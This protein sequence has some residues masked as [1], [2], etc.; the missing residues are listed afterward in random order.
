MR[1]AFSDTPRRASTAMRLWTPCHL[2]QWSR[3][4]GTDVRAHALVAGEDLQGD[5]R[6][7]SPCRRALDV[8]VVVPHT[9]SSA[10][11]WM[12]SAFESVCGTDGRIARV[13]RRINV[14][15]RRPIALTLRALGAPGAARRKIAPGVWHERL[16]RQWTVGVVVGALRYGNYRPDYLHYSL[17]PLVDAPT[18]DMA[19]PPTRI[20][21]RRRH[22]ATAPRTAYS[23]AS[24]GANEG[25]VVPSSVRST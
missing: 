24:M 3:S 14:E 21:L 2:K 4:C 19:T 7:G 23:G 9:P 15:G 16:W 6:L 13:G 18:S 25:E 12:V 11:E 5:G 10:S 8:P 1:R 22:C 17:I 20:A